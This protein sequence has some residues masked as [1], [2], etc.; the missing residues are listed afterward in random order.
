MVLHEER[1]FFCAVN[2]MWIE[3]RTDCFPLA[4]TFRVNQVLFGL[5]LIYSNRLL[6]L[7]CIF[8]PHCCLLSVNYLKP[9]SLPLSLSNWREQGGRAGAD[10]ELNFLLV[11][12]T[13]VPRVAALTTIFH[14]RTHCKELS[15]FSGGNK[16]PWTW[17]EERAVWD[18]HFEKSLLIL[19][20]VSVCNRVPGK[21]CHGYL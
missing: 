4:G 5:I 8:S 19:R 16:E 21:L 10:L 13:T 1:N 2:V 11:L 20:K 9:Q 17:T 7:L 14:C 12:N 6:L 3:R 18:R 15:Y